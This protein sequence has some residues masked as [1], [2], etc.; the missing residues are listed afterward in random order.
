[1]PRPTTKADLLQT[2]DDEFGKL[3][4]LLNSMGDEELSTPFDFRNDPSKKE[5]HWERDKNLRD[6]LVHLYEWH[7]LLLRWIASNQA[8]E[9]KAFLPEPYTWKTYGELNIQFWKNHQATSLKETKAF[10]NKSHK[11]VLKLIDTFTNDALFLKKQF[12]WTGTTT[13]GSYCVSATAS[14]YSWAIKKLKAH[15]KNCRK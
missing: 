6:V 3:Q 8:G 13:L 14:H 15:M 11:D 7:L 4:S 12:S 5:A 10:L 1:M 2:A 9:E